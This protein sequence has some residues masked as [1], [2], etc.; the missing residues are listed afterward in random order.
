MLFICF[1]TLSYAIVRFCTFSSAFTCFHTLSYT[2]KRSHLLL[3]AVQAKVSPQ[4]QEEARWSLVYRLLPAEAGKKYYLAN[5]LLEANIRV[6][7]GEKNL[8]HF[9]KSEDVINTFCI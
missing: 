9:F 5:I 6:E 2:F 3:Y 8:T 4:E 7:Y 1:Y